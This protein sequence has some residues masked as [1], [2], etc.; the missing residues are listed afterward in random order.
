[1]LSNATCVTWI[2]SVSNPID[3]S[4]LLIDK[5]APLKNFADTPETEQVIIHSKVACRTVELVDNEDVAIVPRVLPP[6]SIFNESVLADV[7]LV[8]LKEPLI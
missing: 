8:I 7:L 3:V 2:R 5:L 1:M 6:A 4:A